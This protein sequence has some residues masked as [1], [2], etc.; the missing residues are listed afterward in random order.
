MSG[1]EERIGYAIE[2]KMTQM[3]NDCY[4]IEQRVAEIRDLIPDIK[5]LIYEG[6]VRGESP[7]CGFWLGKLHF[8]KERFGGRSYGWY[9]I[10]IRYKTGFLSKPIVLKY[11]RTDG[12]ELVEIVKF[13]SGVW[14]EYLEEA[15]SLS[16]ELI[17]VN[18]RKLQMERDEEAAQERKQRMKD[19]GFDIDD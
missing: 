5:Q 19:L 6:S 1:R 2:K 10:T 9:I 4:L 17:E 7:H 13:R 18:K 16:A 14:T 11:K 15:K 3:E 12:Y 8:S